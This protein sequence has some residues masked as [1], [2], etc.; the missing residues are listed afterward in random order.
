MSETTFKQPLPIPNEDSYPYWNATNNNQLLL[1]HCKSCGRYRFPPQHL[2]PNCWS[3]DVEWLPVSGKGE[4][5]TFAIAR[6]A[7]RPDWRD[8][9]PYVVALVQLDEG[10]K[11][12]SN[13]IDCAPENVEIGM[14]VAVT[15][16]HVTEEMA[17]PKFR[18]VS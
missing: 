13:V 16:E 17:L 7:I 8:K 2:C 3:E 6:Q 15:F 14:K 12:F 5:Y 11:I 4:V 18:P 1:Q 9:V 10:P